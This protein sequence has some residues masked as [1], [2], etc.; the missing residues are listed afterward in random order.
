MIIMKKSVFFLFALIFVC[1]MSMTSCK[2]V[3]GEKYDQEVSKNDSLLVVALQ[4][5]NEI[6]ELSN[7]MY[8]IS[9]KLDKI[10]GEISLGNDDNNLVKQRERLMQQLQKVQDKIS[11]K[12]A[13][14]DELQKKYSSALSSNKELNRTITRLKNDIENYTSKISSYEN[15]VKE[16]TKKIESLSSDLSTTQ[17]NLETKVKENEQQQEVIAVQDQML[18]EGYYIIASKSKLKELGLVDGGVFSKAR[19]TR[20]TFDVSAFTKIDIREVSEID[21]NSKDAKIL[22]SAPE[23]SYEIIKGYDKNLKLLIKDPAAFWSQSKYLVIKI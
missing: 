9:S 23:S 6:A 15:T 12:Q 17:Q 7:T 2:L 20:G 18:N 1:T 5:S 11:E 10:N 3:S 22:S 8:S 19:L 21:L 13:E 16:Q 4:Q 14:L